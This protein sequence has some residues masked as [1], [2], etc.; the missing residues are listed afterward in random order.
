MSSPPARIAPGQ[1]IDQGPDPFTGWM[2][3]WGAMALENNLDNRA[4][5]Y[6]F[7]PMITSPGY[8]PFF[9]TG[10]RGGAN[11][12]VLIVGSLSSTARTQAID[13]TPYRYAGGLIRRYRLTE[14]GL[15]V[16]PATCP[17]LV[18]PR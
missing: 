1:G 15:S 18:R 17:P 16:P 2:P 8:G 14:R 10:A 9:F 3:F 5:K 4:I 6:L 12:K 13:F 7:Q 11:G